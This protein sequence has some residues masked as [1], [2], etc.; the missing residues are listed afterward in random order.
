MQAKTLKWILPFTVL[1]AGVVG[2]NVVNAVAKSEPEKQEVDSRPV[3]EVET[4]AAQDHQVV[5]QSYGEVKPLESTQLSIQVSGEVEYWHPSFVEGGIVQKGEVLLRIEQDNYEAAVLQAEAELA[6]AEAQLIEEQAQADVA[7]DEARR[8]PTKK[9]TDLFLRKP[10]VMSAK[11][12]V[13]SAKAALQRA[14]RD[15]EN[16]E[17]ITPYNA[18]VVSKQVGLGQFVSMG[19]SVG[20]LNNIETAEVIIPIAGFDS[21]F[22]PERVSGLAATVYQRGANAFSREAVI[23]RDLGTVD[24]QTRMNNLVVRIEDP[25]GLTTGQ[26]AVK[27]GTYVQV[28]FAGKTLKQIYR[29]PQEIVNNQSI[30]LL[31]QDNQLEPRKVQVIREEGKFF[32]IG[33]GITSHDKVVMTPPE[34]PQKGMEVKVAGTD[35][36][37]KP[38]SSQ[39]EKL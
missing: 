13:K 1:I 32:L 19:S 30:W 38:S 20:I 26:P 14:R 29:L 11:A 33:D 2:F 8:F 12:S 17:V 34:Y 39:P 36:P 16:C 23:D 18:L 3:V 15:L 10:Q 6:R 4:L 35:Q 7:A 31:N 22:L 37:A 24:Q 27:Y 9:H 25:Y 21:V 5:I 28:S